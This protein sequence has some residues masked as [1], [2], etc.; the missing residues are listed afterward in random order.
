MRLIVVTIFGVVFG[1]F[2]GISFPT[3]SIT[4]VWT[5]SIPAIHQ[6]SVV[7]LLITVPNMLQ[8]HFPSA[9][10]DGIEDRASGLSAQAILNHAWPAARNARGNGSEPSSNTTMKVGRCVPCRFPHYQTLF[11]HFSSMYITYRCLLFFW[12]YTR[13]LCL[14]L[15]FSQLP[16]K[17]IDNC[18][19]YLDYCFVRT[20]QCLI[21]AYLLHLINEL[22]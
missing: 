14:V 21:L 2:I 3:I 4:K 18:I 11:P 10:L 16:E 8:L 5:W 17:A 12:K 22:G 13:N 9:M 19:L 6:I 20:Q 15:Q 1:F 7:L